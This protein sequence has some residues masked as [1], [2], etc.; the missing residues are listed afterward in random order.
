MPSHSLSWQ[1]GSSHHPT[2]LP[3]DD[4]SDPWLD[5]ASNCWPL[6]EHHC[7]EVFAVSASFKTDESPP[8]SGL[9]STCADALRENRGFCLNCHED[10][11]SFTHCRHPFIA[12]SGCLNH[13]IGQL[14]DDDAHRRWQARMVCY[15]RGG[16]SSR[17]NN[18]TKNRRHLSGQSRGYHQ[19][20]GQ[21]NCH[22]D[23]TYT[24]DHHGGIPR[25][26]TPSAPAPAPQMRFGAAHNPGENTHARQPG[27]FRTGNRQL[28]GGTTPST[29]LSGTPFLVP[30]S[31]VPVASLSNNGAKIASVKSP[32]APTPS[33]DDFH[34]VVPAAG[35]SASSVVPP[36]QV[37][38]FDGEN[39]R[40]HRRSPRS[41]SEFCDGSRTSSAISLTTLFNA[42]PINHGTGACTLRV[43]PQ[44][45]S[46]QQYSC[47][48][49]ASPFH[50]N[51]FIPLLPDQA[52]AIGLRCGTADPQTLF[53][54]TRWRS[55]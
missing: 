47:R 10:N 28:G 51:V 3:I 54:T 26:P 29:T 39:A 32:R 12:A 34:G 24:S 31:R 55:V 48:D 53:L 45:R 7:A 41:W 43:L 35:T 16:K 6:E 9:L 19:V 18:H 52:V 15:H 49:G 42:A 2:V 4:S 33:S 1:T 50:A 22:D 8:S 20:Q 13:E 38:V 11:H 36:S 30:D 46:A 23:N 40:F 5:R 44:A 27:T 37:S 25:S 17:P 21:V 14:G